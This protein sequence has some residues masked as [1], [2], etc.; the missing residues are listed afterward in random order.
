MTDVMVTLDAHD[1]E[2]LWDILK[3]VFPKVSASEFDVMNK[4]AMQLPKKEG[5]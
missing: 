2:L 4:F 5:S 1:W 3:R